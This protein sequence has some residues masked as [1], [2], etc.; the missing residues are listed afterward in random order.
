MAS[1]TWGRDAQR[2]VGMSDD[3]LIEECIKSLAKIH[4]LSYDYVKKLFMKGVVKRWDLD[5]FS[6]G[7]F[8]VFKAYQVSINGF[9]S[10][11]DLSNLNCNSA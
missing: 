3:D 8:T 1:Y 10:E 9:N 5:E 4:K 11:A 7:A 6:L 2:H